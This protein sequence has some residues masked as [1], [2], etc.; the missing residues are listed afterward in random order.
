MPDP[1]PTIT[2]FPMTAAAPGTPLLS[3]D[4]FGTCWTQMT[5]PS[6][7]RTAAAPPP[8]GTGPS[9]KLA[10]TRVSVATGPSTSAAESAIRT[11]HKSVPVRPS[12]AYKNPDFEPKNAVVPDV[13]K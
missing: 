4:E 8:C 12:S 1:D 6:P 3:G 2:R 13:D 7:I 11:R 9:E 10:K 5:V